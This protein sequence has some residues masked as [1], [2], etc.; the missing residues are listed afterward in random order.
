MLSTFAAK[1]RLIIAATTTTT[2]RTEQKNH[3]AVKFDV[4]HGGPC[5]DC[6]GGQTSCMT[7][8]HTASRWSLTMLCEPCNHD[9]EP[10]A[11]NFVKNK[12]TATL[13]QTVAFSERGCSLVKTARAQKVEH[14]HLFERS[15]ATHVTCQRTA[16]VLFLLR[17]TA[18]SW[19]WSSTPPQRACPVMQK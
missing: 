1:S 18:A 12:A 8:K 19:P 13:L 16:R 3:I 7:V 4:G 9:L 2:T 15:L 14:Q 10:R 5:R 6:D 17:K 11:C